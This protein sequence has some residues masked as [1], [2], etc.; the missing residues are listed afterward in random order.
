M[1]CATMYEKYKHIQTIEN[2]PE[3]AIIKNREN[4]GK[5]VCKSE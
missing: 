4:R 1:F 3:E 5:K 2:N